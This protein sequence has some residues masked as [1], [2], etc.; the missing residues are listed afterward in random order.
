M[1][2]WLLAYAAISLLVFDPKLHTGGDES[3]YIILAEALVSGEGYCDIQLIGKPLHRTFPPGLPLLLAPLVMA[4]GR[5]I[6][7]LKLF[8]VL[9]GV[10]GY[11]FFMKIARTLM[12]EGKAS[13]DMGFN[14]PSIATSSP[15]RRKG[16]VLVYLPAIFYLL[17]PVIYTYNHYVLSEVPFTT[18]VMG[19]I[20]LLLKKN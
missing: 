14:S 15:L 13:T 3:I 17:T 7:I 12:L 4:F 18:L 10:I 19:S 9:T 6:V 11:W 16:D 8:I 1:K 2:Y 20:W 5:D